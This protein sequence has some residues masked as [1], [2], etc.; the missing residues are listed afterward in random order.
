MLT[1]S[2]SQGDPSQAEH[3]SSESSKEDQQ[4][5][6]QQLFN[7]VRRAIVEGTQLDQ[8]LHYED[9]DPETGFWI[10]QALDEDGEVESIVPRLGGHQS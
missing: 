6:P 5:S 3:R 4:R 8:V 1:P 7:Q 2:I 10:A 9:I